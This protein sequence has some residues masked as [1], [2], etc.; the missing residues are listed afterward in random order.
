[1]A[2]RSRSDAARTTRGSDDEERR[3]DKPA[4]RPKSLAA[5]LLLAILGCVCLVVTTTAV[6]L[7]MHY[8]WWY[9]AWLRRSPPRSRR[10]QCTVDAPRFAPSTPKIGILALRDTRPPLRRF[11][12]LAAFADAA[13]DNKAKYALYHGYEF[14]IAT[15]KSD[16]TRPAPWSKLTALREAL[17]RFDWLLYVDGDALFANPQPRLEC[18]IDDAYDF[19][20]AED[21]AGYNTGVFFVKNS[22]FASNLLL[23]MWKLGDR[24]AKPNPWWYHPMPF[25]FEQRALHFLTRTPIWQRSARRYPLAVPVASEHAAKAIRSRIKVV[26][27]CAI[28]SYLVRPRLSQDAVH[29]AARYALG[30]FIVHLAGHKAE[31]KAALFEYALTHLVENPPTQAPISSCTSQWTAEPAFNS[32]RSANLSQLRQT[33]LTRQGVR[34][35]GIRHRNQRT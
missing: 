24:L 33:A 18:L 11:R 10:R 19:V 35:R 20:L 31:N 25:E 17:P 14:V 2:R 13:M 22:T 28:N 29:R 3:R 5:K 7:Y 6:W 30:D 34:G 16:P 26:P 4:S 12:Q 23:H 27:Q 9:A 8:G 21:W 1:M 32:T 15:A